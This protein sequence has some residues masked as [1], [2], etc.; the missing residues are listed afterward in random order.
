M[1]ATRNSGSLLREAV[2]KGLSPW[3]IL[4]GWGFIFS[5]DGVGFVRYNE[6]IGEMI[7]LHIVLFIWIRRKY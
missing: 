7:E 5:L 6:G 2:R 1:V 4:C 3:F